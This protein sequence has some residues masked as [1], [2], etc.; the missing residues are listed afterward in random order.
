MFI[1]SSNTY[2]DM[3]MG[4][5]MYIVIYAGIAYVLNVWMAPRTGA[6]MTQLAVFVAAGFLTLAAGTFWELLKRLITGHDPRAELL[7]RRTRLDKNGR[8]LVIDDEK[9]LGLLRR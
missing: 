1:K 5:L 7:A 8:R 6:D 2:L 3:G 9:E 4:C